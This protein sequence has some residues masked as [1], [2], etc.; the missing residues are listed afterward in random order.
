MASL[1]QS[2]ATRWPKEGPKLVL[3]PVS[4][5]GEP[6]FWADKEREAGEALGV[7]CGRG[8]GKETEPSAGMCLAA[9]SHSIA[10][11]AAYCFAS[12]LRAK[13]ALAS[14]RGLGCSPSVTRQVKRFRPGLDSS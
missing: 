10:S 7:G 4:T 1:V 5:S 8:L 12:F 14:P 2:S 6:E 13:T 9:M 3:L 11:L